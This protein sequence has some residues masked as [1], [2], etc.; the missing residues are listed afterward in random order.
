MVASGGGLNH[1]TSTLVHATLELGFLAQILPPC[2]PRMANA[3]KPLRRRYTPVATGALPAPGGGCF[4]LQCQPDVDTE[5]LL[6]LA[7]QTGVS[8]RP[9]QPFLPPVPSHRLRISFALYETDALVQGI[10]RLA[11]ALEVYHAGR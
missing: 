10:A 1:F 2:E 6:P 4:W 7:Q 5:A 11:K 9:G 3:S 8:C